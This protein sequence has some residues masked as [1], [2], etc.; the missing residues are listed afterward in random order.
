MHI[1]NCTIYRGA[2]EIDIEV[3]YAL[4]RYYPAKTYGSPENCHPAEGGEINDLTAYLDGNLFA[5]T[6]AEQRT[7]VRHIYETHYY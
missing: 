7:V 6:P 4:T 1:T 5:L 3:A 2:D